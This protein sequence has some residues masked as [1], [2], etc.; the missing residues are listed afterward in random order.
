MRYYID[1]EF[2]GYGGSLISI[3][4]A[5]ENGRTLY[6]VQSDAFFS[7]MAQANAWDP[8]VK[9]NV[10]PLIFKAAPGAHHPLRLPSAEWGAK[11]A[12]FYG[13]DDKPH[14][15]A[16]WMSDI[17]DLCGLLITGPGTGV[18]M[19]HQTVFTCLRHIDVYPTTL[20]G[21]IQHHALWD[22]LALKQWVEETEKSPHNMPVDA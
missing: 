18:P 1:T 11:I 20:P 13:E 4:I 2:N 17:A 12:E 5:A 3:G 19:P 7:I 15:F 21:A 6:M 9:A 8:W 16:D 14:F 10:L 22:A